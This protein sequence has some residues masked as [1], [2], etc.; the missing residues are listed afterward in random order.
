MNACGAAHQGRI[1]V[2]LRVSWG[3]RTVWRHVESG[4]QCDE[5]HGNREGQ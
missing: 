1:M 4:C 3:E 5:R 2:P